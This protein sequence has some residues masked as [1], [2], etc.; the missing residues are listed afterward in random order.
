MRRCRD[1]LKKLYDEWRTL[2]KHKNQSAVAIK[3]Q[4]E[5]SCSIKTLFN[6]APLNVF[7]V[8]DENFKKFLIN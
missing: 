3:K 4:N 7:E 5:F 8:V 1:K 2:A 6:I